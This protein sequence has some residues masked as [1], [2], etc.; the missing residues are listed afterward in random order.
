MVYV[1]AGV[2]V[3]VAGG[4]SIEIFVTIRTAEVIVMTLIFMEAAMS[5]LMVTVMGSTRMVVNVM[6]L[7]RYCDW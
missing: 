7:V 2:A 1:V 6:R 3:N 5:T 4:N